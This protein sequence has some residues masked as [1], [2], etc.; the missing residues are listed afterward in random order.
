MRWFLLCLPVAAG[1]AGALT[2]AEA[3]ADLD[4]DGIPDLL[5]QTVVIEAVATC[6]PTLFSSGSGVSFYVQDGT[7]GINV[8]AYDAP[9]FPVGPGDL[10][11]V[12]GEIA[13]Y[14]GLTEIEPGS[15]DDYEL[16]GSPGPPDPLQLAR[17]QSVSEPLE[18]MLV[19]AGDPD[20]EQWVTVATQP[21]ASGGGYNF[22]VWNGDA[23]IAVRVNGSTGISV[24]GIEPGARLF[25]TGIGGQYDSE[26]PYSTGY[27]LL[28][29]Y[30]DDIQFFNPSIPATFHLDVSENPFSPTT[31]EVLA[32]EYGGAQ[33]MRFTIKVFDRAGRE[34]ARLVDSRIGGD[35]LEWDGR[36]DHDEFLPIGPY[37]VLLEGIDL[38]GGRLT[39][40]ET[41]VVAAPLE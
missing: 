4:G 6:E 21:S 38:D 5:G 30:Q 1:S 11:R 13:Q 19:R 41:V 29:R 3:R 24:A 31:G 17:H 34:V 27:Q 20:T 18:G 8:Y 39:T 10:I 40:T 23:S 36:D 9:A 28:P 12:T 25:L 26:P 7:A 33:G 15:P 32:I 16:L 35:V 14:N 37:L 2:V 22:N